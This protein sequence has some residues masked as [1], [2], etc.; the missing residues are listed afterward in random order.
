MS[1]TD[2]TNKPGWTQVLAKGK[3]FLLLKECFITI[4]DIY[5]FIIKNF[6][7]IGVCV[8]S[9]DSNNSK[10]Y[11]YSSTLQSLRLPVISETGPKVIVEHNIIL[12]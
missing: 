9:F 2:P 1:N 5:V 6:I 3:Q 4:F 10:V 12:D 11:V 7:L 8:S